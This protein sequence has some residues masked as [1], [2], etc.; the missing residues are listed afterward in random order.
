M[1]N[2][3]WTI[4]AAAGEEDHPN[5]TL[6]WSPIVGK[7]QET[8]MDMTP[9]VQ[10]LMAQVVSADAK[11]KAIMAEQQS[12]L[13]MMSE[14]LARTAEAF[15]SQPASTIHV[16]VPEQAPPVVNVTTP[17]IVIPPTVVNVAAPVV[18]VA[19]SEVKVLMPPEGA[20]KVIYD[21]NGKITGI[22]PVA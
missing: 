3:P 5:G 11:A 1:A 4:E 12:Q 2:N 21:R 20:K 16:N 15:A 10:A 6:A 13:D 22:E 19:P 7:A 9:V 17:E 18:N 14:R 8:Q